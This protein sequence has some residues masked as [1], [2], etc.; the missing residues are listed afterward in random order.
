ME[1]SPRSSSGFTLIELL[2][3]IAIIAI[4]ASLLLSAL[5]RAKAKAQSSVCLNNQKQLNL[6]W[7]LYINENEDKLA[8]NVPDGVS[9]AKPP[10]N[11]IWGRMRYETDN[12][13]ST[14]LSESTNKSLLVDPF[15]GR[16]GPFVQAAGV[17][18]CPGD[19]SY[20]TIEGGRHSRVRSYSMNHFMGKVEALSLPNGGESYATHSSVHSPSDRWVLIDEHEDSISLGEFRFYAVRWLT[21][22]WNDLPAARHGGIGTLSFADGHVESRKWLDRRS[23]VP[24]LRQRQ[25][26]S[27]GGNNRDVLWLWLRTT[28]PEPAY[29]P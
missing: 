22:G 6:A 20:V 14:P 17:F 26:S 18:R 10:P 9:F 23:R 15:P 24:V 4:L 1:R 11:W 19:R 5:N 3:V 29:M 8:P 12:Q 13:I 25:G 27:L 16:I 7:H 28:T 21:S 2:V